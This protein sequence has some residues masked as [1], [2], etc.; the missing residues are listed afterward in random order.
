MRGQVG[1]RDTITEFSTMVDH[2]LK[3]RMQRG[4]ANSLPKKVI[5]LRDGVSDSGVDKVM[6]RTYKQTFL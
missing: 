6:V 3:V 5:Y 4:G 2:L 1:A